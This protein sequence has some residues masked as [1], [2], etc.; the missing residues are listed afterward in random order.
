[1][2]VTPVVLFLVVAALL[3]AAGSGADV[4]TMSVVLDGDHSYE[5]ADALVVVGGTA[6]VPADGTVSS[7]FV[8]G[9]TVRVAGTVTGDVSVLDG[10]A[11]LESTAVVGGNLDDFGNGAVVEQGATVRGR[12]TTGVPEVQRT[13]NPVGG[14]L[15]ALALA[16]VAALFARR[17]PRLPATVGDAARSHPVVCATVGSLATS[18]LLAVFVAMAFTVVLLPVALLGLLAGMA[19]VGYTAVAYGHL[20]GAGLRPWLPGDRPA[21]AAALGT[22][23]YLGG[24]AALN[25]V[26]VV[27]GTLALLVT[28]AGLGA[29][30]VT[31]FGLAP[32]EPPTL[33]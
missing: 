3:L 23:L 13:S 4:S 2:E 22:L 30:V 11:V 32:Y 19:V 10:R 29:T 27:G 20:V 17:A 1:M 25:A 16:A 9:G 33:A 26:P 24:L 5:V 6:T 21:L 14:G 12:R 7:V 8:A 15:V 31:Y 28:V 18:L